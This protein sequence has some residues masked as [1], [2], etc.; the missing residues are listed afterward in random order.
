MALDPQNDANDDAVATD[1]ADIFAIVL[2]AEGVG[3]NDDFF[4]L[5]GHSLLAVEVVAKIEAR[6]GV[7]LP[8]SILFERPNPRELAAAVVEGMGA[9][10]GSRDVFLRFIGRRFAR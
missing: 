7:R 10:R 4:A 8:P 5:R 1:V 9:T 3:V 6:F 2:G